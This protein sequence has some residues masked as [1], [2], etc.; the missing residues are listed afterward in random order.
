MHFAGVVI[1]KQ[2]ISG[3]FIVIE[4]QT[5]RELD[6]FVANWGLVA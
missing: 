1:K 3:E 4:T 2:D 6:L 5:E